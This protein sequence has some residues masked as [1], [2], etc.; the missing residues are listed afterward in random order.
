MY[1]NEYFVLKRQTLLFLFLFL[2]SIFFFYNILKLQHV[3]QPNSDFRFLSRL[4]HDIMLVIIIT[5]ARHG[6]TLHGYNQLL[7]IYIYIIVYTIYS[8]VIG[9]ALG[10]E[11]SG[12][13]SWPSE[14]PHTR[15]LSPC[16]RPA[17]GIRVLFPLVRHRSSSPTLFNYFLS[18]LSLLIL[19][20]SYL[21]SSINP[22]RTLCGCH[23]S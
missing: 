8:F 16:L 6:Q 19:S 2:F 10:L 9:R 17:Q 14:A 21:A 3:R 18:V 23:P 11:L 1:Y 15:H 4:L 13:G 5:I 12:T 20:S 22:Q 7:H